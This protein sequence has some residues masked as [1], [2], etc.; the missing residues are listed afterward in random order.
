LKQYPRL[1]AFVRPFFDHLLSKAVAAALENPRGT[2]RL[3]G[4]GSQ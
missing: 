1:K 4:Q 3:G 2:P